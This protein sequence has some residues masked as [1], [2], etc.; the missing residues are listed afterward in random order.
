MIQGVQRFTELG[1][2]A[3]ASRPAGR[4]AGGAEARLADLHAWPVQPGGE[5]RAVPAS[6]R[7]AHHRPSMTLL[8]R[9]AALAAAVLLAAAA[10]AS[11]QRGPQ[12][13]LVHRDPRADSLAR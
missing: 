9:R 1:H 8:G 6:R 10:A 11:G 7:M 4:P 3:P 12:A 13:S 2:W 5:N